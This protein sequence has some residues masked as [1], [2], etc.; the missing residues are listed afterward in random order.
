MEKALRIGLPIVILVLGYVLYE[1][2]A[3]EVREREK[4]A[5][6]EGAIID[7]MNNIKEAQFAYRDTYNKF[8]K[9]FD[10]LTRAMREDKRPIVKTINLTAAD[11]SDSAV[12]GD[13]TFVSL[14]QIAFG[15]GAEDINL[16]SMSYVPY[17]PNNAKFKMDADIIEVGTDRI[18]VPVFEVKDPEPYN[19]E[20]T[21]TLGSLFE[22]QFTGNWQ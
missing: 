12:A 8:A 18:L 1:S 17:N 21:L 19:E 7:R 22:P 6:I 5:K 20:R 9:D 11:G 4:I 13:T 10:E 14:K 2:V 16:D 3:G 15:A